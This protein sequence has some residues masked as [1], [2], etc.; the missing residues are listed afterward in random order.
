MDKTTLKS[1]NNKAKYD[2]ELSDFLEVGIVLVSDEIK[3]VQD[4][5]IDLVGSYACIIENE[6]FL[7]NAGI[8]G[9]NYNKIDIDKYPLLKKGK[10]QSV[11]PKKLLLHKKQI[12]KYIKKL[13]PGYT[14]IVTEVYANEKNRIKC[15]LALG[16][17]K[18]Q[19][20]KREVIKKRDSDRKLREL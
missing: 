19:R 16:K 1:K 15:T 10:E 3:I 9:I 14:L 6:V 13:Q 17:G 18:D 5:G 4:R 8:S 2:Y 20:D 11:R 7:L 12:N